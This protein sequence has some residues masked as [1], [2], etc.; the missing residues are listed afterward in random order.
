M[1]KKKSTLRPLF[2]IRLDV[3][4]VMEEMDALDDL[5]WESVL[6][7]TDEEFEAR[8]LRLKNSLDSLADEARAHY[9]EYTRRPWVKVVRGL[10]DRTMPGYPIE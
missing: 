1:A 3:D 8:E 10:E 6:P 4:R 5:R 9:K 7:W 2:A